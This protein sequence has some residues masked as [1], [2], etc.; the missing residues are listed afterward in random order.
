MENYSNQQLDAK[1]EAFMARKTEQY[2]ELMK[3]KKVKSKNLHSHF[4]SAP[5]ISSMR[6]LK[7]QLLG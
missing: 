7:P 2:P 5:F 6:A 3:T 1:I 4:A